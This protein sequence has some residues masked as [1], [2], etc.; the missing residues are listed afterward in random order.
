LFNSSHN[1]ASPFSVRSC[2][3]S[4]TNREADGLPFVRRFMADK[5]KNTSMLSTLNLHPGAKHPVCFARIN[6]RTRI[7]GRISIQDSAAVSFLFV[8]LSDGR[9]LAEVFFFH[10]HPAASLAYIL[11][12]SQFIFTHV[13]GVNLGR[14]AKA[15]IFRIA[16]GIAQ[17]TG[18][19]RHRTAIFT[20]ISHNI[21]PP[22]L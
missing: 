8:Q 1:A 12:G 6:I 17:M 7:S 3:W 18:C 19:I 15:A 9:R 5:S 4:T 21:I 16:A 20:G 10:G 11:H 14:T 22:F 2:H 13:F